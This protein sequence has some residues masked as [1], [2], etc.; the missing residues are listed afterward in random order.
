MGNAALKS[1]FLVDPPGAPLHSRVAHTNSE[2][3]KTEK[4]AN[5][6]LEQSELAAPKFKFSLVDVKSRRHPVIANMS[7]QSIE[8]YDRYSVP[9]SAQ[10][11]P[12]QDKTESFERVESM[13][14][15]RSNDG[16]SYEPEKTMVET[17]DELRTMIAITGIWVAFCEHWSPNFRYSTKQVISNGISE[18]S[19]LRRM[20][21]GQ[22]L[23]LS[24][25]DGSQQRFSTIDGA[26]HKLGEAH[27]SILPSIPASPRADSPVA[28]PERTSSTSTTIVGDEDSHHGVSLQTR[29][30]AYPMARDHVENGKTR[31]SLV[32]DNAGRPTE[33]VVAEGISKRPGTFRRVVSRLSNMSAP[34]RDQY[35]QASNSA[36]G[37]NFT[38]N[39]ATYAN[40]LMNPAFSAFPHPHFGQDSQSWNNVPLLGHDFNLNIP[41]DF[42]NNHGFFQNQQSELPDYDGNDDFYDNEMNTT[43]NPATLLASSKQ[44]SGSLSSPVKLPAAIKLQPEP[45]KVPVVDPNH[46]AAELRARLLANKRPGSTTPSAPRTAQKEMNDMKLKSGSS[47]RDDASSA[48]QRPKPSVAMVIPKGSSSSQSLDKSSQKSSK[49][50]SLPTHNADIEGLISEY[51]ASEVDKGPELPVIGTNVSNSTI[52]KTD[53]I[54]NRSHVDGPHSIPTPSKNI[55]PKETQVHIPGSPES[56]EIHSDQEPVINN[57]QDRPNVEKFNDEP[58]K[59]AA[60]HGTSEKPGQR[61]APQMPQSRASDTMQAAVSSKSRQSSLSQPLQSKDQRKSVNP[62]TEPRNI[63]LAQRITHPR[64]EENRSPYVREARNGNVQ[65][66]DA[67]GQVENFDRQTPAKPPSLIA[68]SRPRLPSHVTTV[69]RP[70]RDE[71]AIKQSEYLAALYKMQMAEEKTPTSRSNNAYD[72]AGTSWIVKQA[73][74]HDRPAVNGASTENSVAKPVKQHAPKIIPKGTSSSDQPTHTLTHHQTERIQKMGIDLSPQGLGDLFDFLEYHR[75]Y[76]PEYREGFFARQKRLRALEAEKLALERE[77]ILQFDH[78]TSMRSQS[79][80]A[81]EQTEPPTPV[82][83]H[84]TISIDTA[85]VKPMPPP[86]ILPK[87]ASNGGSGDLPGSANPLLS[88]TRTNGHVTPRESTQNSPS[89]LKRRRPEDEVDLDQSK[90][91]ARVETDLRSN[92]KGQDISPRTTAHVHPIQERRYSLDQRPPAGYQFRGRSRSPTD[93]RRSLSPRRRISDS[94]YPSRQNSLAYGRE[95]GYHDSREQ[96][97]RRPSVDGQRRDSAGQYMMNYPEERNSTYSSHNMSSFPSRGFRGGSRGGRSGYQNY[98]PRGGYPSHASSPAP[99]G[100]KNSGLVD[101]KAGGQSRSESS[102]LDLP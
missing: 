81:R 39:D 88:A 41:S 42:V 5:A 80:A 62:N 84:G 59:A 38:R 95:K 44:S 90:K 102:G 43:E 24:G 26:R 97:Y 48:E 31:R 20:S 91:V 10:A 87:R 55:G 40:T 86:L 12:H 65:G 85:A 76:V 71:P 25:E 92:V 17:D 69:P 45:S 46:R 28:A 7:K 52:G 61:Q 27:K 49:V 54:I 53:G 37:N 74:I 100:W 75:Y 6:N 15:E 16:E 4:T 9:T 79:V 13:S 83:V 73:V 99:S 72:E 60:K 18:L 51:R 101:P 94:S 93:R 14:G 3:R 19:N 63:P 21:D 77:S 50:R 34:F 23:T 29:R 89:N 82:S 11:T 58:P 35:S 68:Q 33:R 32:A 64:E 98:K 57:G 1:D 78:F 67:T 56:G 47:D 30:P 70:D 2:D 8:V 36:A 22:S 96:D 66:R